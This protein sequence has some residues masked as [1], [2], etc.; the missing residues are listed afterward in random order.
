MF[1]KGMETDSSDIYDYKVTN[2]LSEYANTKLRPT[3]FLILTN[4]SDT[5]KYE[6]LEYNQELLSLM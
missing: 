1:Y 5:L 3:E 2:K 6:I 4:N